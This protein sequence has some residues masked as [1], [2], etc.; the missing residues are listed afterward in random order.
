MAVRS[1]GWPSMRTN[2]RSTRRELSS[3]CPPA[4]GMRPRRAIHAADG[5]SDLR[6][7]SQLVHEFGSLPGMIQTTVRDAVEFFDRT[8]IHKAA[9]DEALRALNDWWK[10]TMA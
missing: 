6:L 7:L 2:H 9:F 10:E 5:V 4:M 8:V 1:G 3:T